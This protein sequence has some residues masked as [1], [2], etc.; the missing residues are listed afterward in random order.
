M[1][2]RCLPA[3]PS[4]ALLAGLL[5]PVGLFAQQPQV[6]EVVIGVDVATGE[7]SYSLD[8][9]VAFRGDRVVFS[10]PGVESW[11]VRF[12][13]DTPFGNR[14]ITGSGEQS[15]TV[16]ILPAAAFQSY[17]YDVS[18]TVGGETFTEDPE[19]IVRDRRH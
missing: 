8:P 14:E 1:S 10:A 4:L 6:H 9:V 7:L 11:T 16:P 3:L 17:K 13:E 19:I 2:T 15:R 12:P 5:L 18:V